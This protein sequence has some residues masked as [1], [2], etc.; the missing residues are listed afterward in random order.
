MDFKSRQ[1]LSRKL[2]SWS[3]PKHCTQYSLN[4][5]VPRARVIMHF[6]AHPLLEYTKTKFVEIHQ[7]VPAVAFSDSIHWTALQEHTDPA[8]QLPN[9]VT[10]FYRSEESVWNE[11]PIQSLVCS[12]K[13]WWA[14]FKSVYMGYNLQ[15]FSPPIDH[16]FDVQSIMYVV[17]RRSDTSCCGHASSASG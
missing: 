8:F 12:D 9:S 5:L 4:P 10:F 16:R 6:Q 11:W 14:I 15:L 13:R 17:M 1:S 7:I 2:P 3:G